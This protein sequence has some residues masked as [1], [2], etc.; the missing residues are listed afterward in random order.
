MKLL[1]LFEII[2]GTHQVRVWHRA[3]ERIH[4]ARRLTRQQA[5]RTPT[6]LVREKDALVSTRFATTIHA[7]F[8]TIS[9]QDFGLGQIPLDSPRRHSPHTLPRHCRSNTPA[10][11]SARPR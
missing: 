11:T 9:D 2:G 7:N 1:L 8:V 10:T 4:D 3:A 6:T 5:V